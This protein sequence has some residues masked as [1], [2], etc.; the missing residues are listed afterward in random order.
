[1]SQLILSVVPKNSRLLRQRTKFIATTDLSIKAA[2]ISVRRIVFSGFAHKPK[3]S[4][5]ST[6]FTFWCGFF[7]TQIIVQPKKSKTWKK[8]KNE[9]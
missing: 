2:D 7:D 5:G 1:L 4:G 8:N 9:L 3:F 6:D